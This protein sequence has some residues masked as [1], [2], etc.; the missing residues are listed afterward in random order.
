MRT[1]IGDAVGASLGTGNVAEILADQGRLDESEDRFR[2]VR[3][4]WS[5]AGDRYGEAFADLHLARISARA[6]RL[7]D[8]AQLFTTARDEFSAIGASMEVIESDLRRAEGLLFASRHQEARALLVEF[9]LPPV[10]AHRPPPLVPV[11]HRT[12]GFVH[13]Q[14]GDLVGAADSFAR[15]L[16]AAREQGA[17]YEELLVLAA[18]IRLALIAGD[19]YEALVDQHQ[20]LVSELGVIALPAIPG[21]S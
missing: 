19:R 6:G 12:V 14:D 2:S 3:R 9:D 13:L 10:P 4:I 16:T 1:R 7:D 11:A 5:A 21:G 18:Q 8:A 20:R 15:A 17:A